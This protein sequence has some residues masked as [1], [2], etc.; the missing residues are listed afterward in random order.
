MSVKSEIKSML[1]SVTGIGKVYDR[2]VHVATEADIKERLIHENKV[3][4]IFFIEV[5][6]SYADEEDFYLKEK[7]SKFRFA[8]YYGY[9]FNLNS[10]A[11]VTSIKDEIISK[12]NTN[13]DLNGSV[14]EHSNIDMTD[15][16]FV[17]FGNILC[18]LLIFELTV[19][20]NIEVTPT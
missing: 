10:D 6:E 17:S 14:S 18:H 1:E 11:S 16:I 13:E 4:A 12:F 3:N 19:L 7:T 20:N 15:N 5:A 2:F 9:N 8:F